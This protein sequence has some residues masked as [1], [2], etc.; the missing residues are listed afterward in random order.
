MK[1]N[2]K[3]QIVS[4]IFEWQKINSSISYKDALFALYDDRMI[5]GKELDE[6]MPLTL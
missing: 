6:L 2:R 5:T 4:Q 3:E 1:K